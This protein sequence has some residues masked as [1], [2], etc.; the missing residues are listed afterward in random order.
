MS[1]LVQRQ[2][3]VLRK[4]CKCKPEQRRKI[5][6]EGGKNLKTCLSECALNI[7]NGNVKLGPTQFKKLIKYKDHVRALS[8]KG[9]TYKKAE[10]IV[11]EGGFLPLL[12]S[13]I[14][15]ALTSAAIK[16]IGSAIKKKQQQRKKK[17]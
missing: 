17:K 12:L 2:L 13:P 1:Q 4:L 3:P 10:K 11:Q 9:V 8:K 15:G 16:G 5:F 6:V 14:L 7:L